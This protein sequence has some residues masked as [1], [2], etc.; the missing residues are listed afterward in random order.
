MW[1]DLLTAY[2]GDAITYD[3]SGNPLTYR[4]G[5]TFTW[6]GGRE[7]TTAV[8]NGVTTAYLYNENGIR[9]KKTVGSTTTEYFLDG[10][11]Y[12]LRLYIL[13]QEQRQEAEKSVTSPPL[14]IESSYI[15]KR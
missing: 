6:Q 8:N 14:G 1:S 3:A 12:D 11:T 9:T 15:R 7:L 13:Q 10:D 4:D 5:M 2:D